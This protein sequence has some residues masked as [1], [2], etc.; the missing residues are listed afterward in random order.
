MEKQLEK[1]INILN[2][3]PNIT[4]VLITTE[5]EVYS[6]ENMGINLLIELIEDIKTSGAKLKNSCVAT[7]KLDRGTAFLLS[8]ITV[9]AVFAEEISKLA[10]EVILGNDIQ[11]TYNTLVEY[12]STD[13]SNMFLAEEWVLHIHE[14]EL[15]HAFWLLQ[16]KI[17][18]LN[19]SNLN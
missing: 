6:Y 11:S 10:Q 9:Q 14:K 7:R 16:Q 18:E 5:N 13:T 8:K 19:F 12:I 15:E 17:K 4:F 2:T 1:I 3:N